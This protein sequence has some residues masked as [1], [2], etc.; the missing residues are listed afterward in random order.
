MTDEGLRLIAAA[1]AV[2]LGAIGPGIGLGVIFG[3][4]LTAIGR[5]PE[6]EATIRVN[7]FLGFA[8]TES[9]FIFA[10][11]VSLLILFGVV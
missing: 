9:I 3:N 4:A 1:L 10:L 8:L 5:N 6:A 11:V 7:M 2:G